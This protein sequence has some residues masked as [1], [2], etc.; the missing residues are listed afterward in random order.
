MNVQVPGAVVL[1][2]SALPAVLEVY[3]IQ[4]AVG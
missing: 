3:S 1:L 2:E 4:G